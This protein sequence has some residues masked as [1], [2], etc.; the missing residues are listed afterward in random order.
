MRIQFL[1]TAAA[2]GIPA[3]WCECPVCTKAM[4]DGGKELRRR[5]SYRI[6]SDTL[7]DFGPDAFWQATEFKIDLTKIKRIVFTHPHED[8]LNVTDLYWRHTPCFS[9]VS[10]PLRIFG[11]RSIFRRIISCA[12]LDGAAIDFDELQIEV[13]ML[14][15]AK[16]VVDE[17]LEILPLR[18]DHAPGREAQILVL[19]R[20]GRAVLLANDTGFLPEESWKALHGVKLDAAVIE[21]TSALRYADCRHGHM[22]ANC[23]VAFRDE[24]L[25]L[26]C[27]RK[28][29]P[30]F[31]NHFSHNGGANHQE[32]VEWF[33]PH[34]IGVAWDGMVLEV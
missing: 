12:A 15:D 7:V 19:R 34:G 14:E 6:D 28:E 11:S 3:L 18:A 21:S 30:V 24:L 5:C 9:Q 17:D 13:N 1:G 25:K 32:L 26:G 2:E 22:G 33:A 8:H 23:S 31:V 29:T 20:N 16:Q 10:H 27:I 4:R